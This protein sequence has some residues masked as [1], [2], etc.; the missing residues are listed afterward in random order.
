LAFVQNPRSTTKQQT[1][2]LSSVFEAH[3]KS[4]PSAEV[5]NTLEVLAINRRLPLLPEIHTL[6]EIMKAEQEK[7]TEVL[8]KSATELSEIQREKLVQTLSKRL[9]RAVTLQV[10]VDPA[11]IG[12]AMI[13]A[14]DLVID[15]TVRGK[16]NTLSATL[17]A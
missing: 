15:G 1:E 3:T 16:L 10:V 4:K 14:G 13:S 2:L 5:E 12:G 17:I 6:Y 11:L 9:Q 7:T 8:V